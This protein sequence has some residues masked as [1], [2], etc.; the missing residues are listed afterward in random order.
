MEFKRV[1][2][3]GSMKVVVVPQ[4]SKI[5]V[6]DQVVFDDISNLKKFLKLKK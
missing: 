2:K 6:G 5:N 4:K 3:M 1:V